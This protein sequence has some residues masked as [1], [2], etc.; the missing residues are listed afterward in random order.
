MNRQIK[1]RGIRVDDGRWVY[2]NLLQEL[3]STFISANR[4]EH[5]EILPD[6][7]A[8]Y[9]GLK[10]KNGKQIYEGDVFKPFTAGP[11]FYKVVFENG[12]F[13]IYNKYGYY[14]LL[15]KFIEVAERLKVDLKVVGNIYENPELI[16]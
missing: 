5:F 10:D 1:F 6:T 13:A 16:K 14:S 15:S 9:T 11:N 2:G 3:G 12:S 7:S 8:Q 4:N